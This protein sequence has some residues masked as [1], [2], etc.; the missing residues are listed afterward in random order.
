[1]LYPFEWTSP[2]QNKGQPWAEMRV[3]YYNNTG[4]HWANTA[5]GNSNGWVDFGTVVVSPGYPNFSVTKAGFDRKDWNAN[6]VAR[7]VFV[8]WFCDG[9]G[10]TGAVDWNVDNVSIAP[11]NPEPLVIMSNQLG[12][13]TAAPQWVAMRPNDPAI[14]SL[15]RLSK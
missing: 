5:A 10:S 12:Y 3:W 4:W 1:M 13:D 15:E 11:V 8:H 2:T 9:G 14:R 7:D 6:G